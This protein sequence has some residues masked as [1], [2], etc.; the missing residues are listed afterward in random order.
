MP[1]SLPAQRRTELAQRF[2]FIDATQDHDRSDVQAAWRQLLDAGQSPEKL[3]Q[4]PEFFKYMMDTAKPGEAACELYLVRR[5]SD[6]R[7]VGLVPGRTTKHEIGVRLG[8]LT[9]F[10]RSVPVYQVLGSVLL[11]DAG[12]EGLP[13]FVLKNLLQRHPDCH[14]LL[15]QAMPEEL[16]GTISHKGLSSHVMHGWRDCHTVPLPA[17]VD[18]YLQKLSAKKRYNLSRQVRLLAKEAGEVKLVRVE[19]ADQVPALVDAMRALMS[20]ADLAVQATQARLERLARHG[21][22]H[23]YVLRC[24]E[25]AVA[26]VQ[27][28]RSNEVWHVHNISCKQEYMSLSVGTSVV[29]LALQD[30]IANGNFIHADFGYGT[31]NQEFRSTHVLQRRGKLLLC[32]RHGVA[33]LVFSLHAAQDRMNE[34]LIGGVK[35]FRRRLKERGR[36]AG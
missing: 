24:G 7:I 17:D 2:E 11:L 5:R 29:H 19:H 30:T 6:A 4:L 18:T 22:L 1:V 16:A 31:P 27:G 13:G 9:L 25:Q 20:D 34:A 36:A 26:M 12:E 14:A 21:L 23:S 28:T 32:R 15:M 10:E 35:A 33:N 8:P 3:Y